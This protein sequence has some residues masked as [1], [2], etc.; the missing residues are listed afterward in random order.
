MYGEQEVS[1]F[2]GVRESSVVRSRGRSGLASEAT[3]AAPEP[4]TSL[5]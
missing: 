5:V 1:P 2:G 4:T 3:G